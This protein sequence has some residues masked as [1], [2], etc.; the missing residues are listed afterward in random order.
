VTAPLSWPL[1]YNYIN[2]SITTNPIKC[3]FCI[4]LIATSI[5]LQKRKRADSTLDSITVLTIAEEAAI[6]ATIDERHGKPSNIE[7][8]SDE[9]DIEQSNE[10]ELED[11]T[12]FWVQRKLIIGGNETIILEKPTFAQREQRLTEQ[13]SKFLILFSYFYIIIQIYYNGDIKHGVI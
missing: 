13:T 11:S 6:Q 10:V 4:L 7:D 3:P 2:I 12:L 1:F 5:S 9:S 8:N